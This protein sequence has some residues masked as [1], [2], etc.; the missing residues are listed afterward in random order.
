MLYDKDGKPDA[1]DI[2]MEQEASVPE[3]CRGPELLTSEILEAVRET[4][5]NK[6]VGINGIPADMLKVLGEEGTKELV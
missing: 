6:A 5:K 3:D 1:K 2:D 4:K